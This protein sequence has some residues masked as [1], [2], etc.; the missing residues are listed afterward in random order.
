MDMDEIKKEK[1]VSEETEQNAAVQTNNPREDTEILKKEGSS[2]EKITEEHQNETEK[3][4]PVKNT[5]TVKKSAS[6]KISGDSSRQPDHTGSADGGSVPPESPAGRPAESGRQKKSHHI[7]KVIVKYILVF[8]IAGCGAFAGSYAAIRA[9]N[10]QR[11]KE[12][13]NAFGSF[14][15]FPYGGD[16]SES[17]SSG[18][19][20]G[21]TIE[22]TD[23]GIEIVGF[24]TGSNAESAGLKQGDIITR[25]DGKS[26]DSVT[27]ISSYIS[28]KKVG[29]K[30]KVTVKR[31]N[32]EKTYTVKLVKKNL[33]AYSIPSTPD[34]EENQNGGSDNSS[35]PKSLPGTDGD[36][37]QFEG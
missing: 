23:D 9:N 25:V 22:Q 14:G 37:S 19:A 28:S 27:E 31:N 34:S 5:E 33:S 12:I 7:W 13:Q 2:N 3:S 18:A 24:A 30:V 26:Y 1:S 36:S 32:T 35:T 16:R 11:E 15:Q 21:V 8:L 29:D 6:G 20:L 10:A 4:A 17:Q